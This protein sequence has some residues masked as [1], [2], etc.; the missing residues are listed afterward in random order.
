MIEIQSVDGTQAIQLASVKDLFSE[1]QQSLGIPLDF[2]GFDDELASLPGKY[3]APKGG[4]YLALYNHQPVGCVAFYPMAN[5]T[6][7]LKRLYVNPDY[8]GKSIGKTLITKAM[9]DAYQIG[10]RYMRLDSLKRL[11]TASRMYQRLGFYPIEPYNENPHDDVYYME[12]V[13]E[14]VLNSLQE[15]QRL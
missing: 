13:L 9:R 12:C 7:E 15:L 6:C 2:Q 8:Q 10:Y 5:N 11:D 4:L 3:A 14:G 1:Y